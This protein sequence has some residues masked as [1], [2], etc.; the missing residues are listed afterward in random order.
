MPV[1][2]PKAHV[3]PQRQQNPS[4]TFLTSAA[5][6]PSTHTTRNSPQEGPVLAMEKDHKS[7]VCYPKHLLRI[8]IGYS[9]PSRIGGSASEVGEISHLNI[10]I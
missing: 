8:G 10:R 9:Q 7:T 5:L 4:R 3:S 2:S 1:H 6:K